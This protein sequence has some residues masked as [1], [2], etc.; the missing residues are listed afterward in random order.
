MVH[1]VEHTEATL[2]GAQSVDRALALL[3][4]VAR[5]SDEGIALSAIVR[6]SGLNKATARRLLLALMRA[7]LIGQA[8][9]RRSYFLG[10]EA[11]FLGQMAQ[12][13]H[14]LLTHAMDSLQRLARETGDAA[15]VSVRRG[16]YG[17]CLHR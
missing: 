4:L 9:D 15:F 7:G 2:G 11:Y 12:S 5:H 16:L 10:E 6:E 1:I 17:F 8:A 14:G 3:S 13:R